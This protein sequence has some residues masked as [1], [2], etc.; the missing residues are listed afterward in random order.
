MITFA[1]EGMVFIIHQLYYCLVIL[2]LRRFIFQLID[3]V[4]D[5]WIP[6]DQILSRKYQRI[7]R[8]FRFPIDYY[9]FFR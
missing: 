1:V 4:M 3:N 6:Q 7:L 9:H 5:P 2:S 8:N